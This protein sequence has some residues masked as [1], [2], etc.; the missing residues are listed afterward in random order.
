M[1]NLQSPLNTNQENL[2]IMKLNRENLMPLNI[3][4]NCK[5]IWMNITKLLILLLKGTIIKISN[6]SNLI[7]SIFETIF[8]VVPKSITSHN[9][10]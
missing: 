9:L 2:R 4:K 10:I 3:T 6:K 5:K 1:L 7:D 8:L